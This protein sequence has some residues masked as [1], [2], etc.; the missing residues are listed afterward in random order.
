M[1]VEENVTDV[2]VCL[3]VAGVKIFLCYPA[4]TQDILGNIMEFC[5]SSPERQV[6]D[7]T[8]F[9]YEL[10]KN[11]PNKCKLIVTINSSLS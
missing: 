1:I 9:Y 10:L 7:K 11:N 8:R 3:L 4:Q 5:M 6:K 2:S